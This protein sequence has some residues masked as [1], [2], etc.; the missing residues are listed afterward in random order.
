MIAIELL[1]LT[2]QGATS[3]C[4]FNG[5]RHAPRQMT[6]H[7]PFC[8]ATMRMLDSKNTRLTAGGGT[9]SQVFA[10]LGSTCQENGTPIETRP[11]GDGADILGRRPVDAGRLRAD[12]KRRQVLS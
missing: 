2:G 8:C 6:A 11:G 7:T 4:F 3:A 9:P 10:L 12:L 1:P 5:R